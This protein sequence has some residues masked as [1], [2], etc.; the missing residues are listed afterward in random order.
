MTGVHIYF[1]VAGYGLKPWQLETDWMKE[2]NKAILRRI[3][4]RLEGKIGSLT[5]PTHGDEITAIVSGP[6]YRQLGVKIEGC[7]D[8]FVAMVSERL[9]PINMN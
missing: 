8:E 4:A 3:R 5:C 9:K 1:F 7:C 6:S 2:E